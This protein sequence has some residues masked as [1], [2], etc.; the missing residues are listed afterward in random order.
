MVNE[1][2]QTKYGALR[3]VKKD[4]YSLFAG[5][6][7]AKAPVGE[8]RWK[9][10][11]KPES[12]EGEREAVKFPHIA[13]QNPQTPPAP[14]MPGINYYQEFYSNPEDIPERDEDC[15]YLNIWVPDETVE[16]P[17][18]GFPVAFWIHGGAFMGGYGSEKE[19]DG[20]TYAK[21]G[22]ILVT[23]NYRLGALGFLYL[24]ELAQEDKNGSSGNY[25]ILDQIAALRWVKENIAAFGGNPEKVTIMGQSAGA[26]SVQTIVCSPL[27][28]GLLMG[29][30]MQSGGG[31]YN[32]IFHGLSIE[33]AAEAGKRFMEIAGAESLADLRK[34]P[35]EELVA[36]NGKLMME[37]M[38]AGKGFPFSP[39]IDGYLL[40]KGYDE[41]IAAGEIPDIHYLLGSCG[42]DIW[43]RPEDTAAGIYSSLYYGCINWSL[44]EQL[45]GRAPAYVYYFDRKLPGNE[46]GAFHSAELWY[47]FH[48]LSRCWRPMEERDYVLA[49]AMSGYWANFVKTGDPNGEG[50]PQ[51][52]PCGV[53]DHHVQILK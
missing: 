45:H 25:G 46:D 50:L 17:E 48:T 52:N 16:K 53:E 22:V 19:F 6:P 44:A 18:G 47:T 3:G 43:C 49:D 41:T 1:M 31:L 33:E 2:I 20:E 30:V 24:P 9:A 38:M 5:V 37:W 42:D 12:W 11:E 39:V 32:H 8:L 40:K 15:L 23:V 34:I 21:N 27:S 51:W 28:E 29:A 13:W 26:M 35:A 36:V 14:G 7:Y 10:P 4:G